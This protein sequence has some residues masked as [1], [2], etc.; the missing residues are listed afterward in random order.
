MGGSVLCNVVKKTNFLSENEN[1]L[2]LFGD[3]RVNLCDF[4][5]GRH[6]ELQK[7]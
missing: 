6:D 5:G 2:K 4:K 7:Y 3:M 1:A